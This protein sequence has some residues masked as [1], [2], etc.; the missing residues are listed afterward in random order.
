[1]KQTGAVLGMEAMA[2]APPEVGRHAAEQTRPLAVAAREAGLEVLAYILEIAALEA[3]QDP[4]K[5][6]QRKIIA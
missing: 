1:L 2:E 6:R 4:R 5:E 3:E